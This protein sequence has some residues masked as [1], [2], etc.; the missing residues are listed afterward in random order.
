MTMHLLDCR[1]TSV[2]LA[3]SRDLDE[4]PFWERLTYQS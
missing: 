4:L 3:G 2:V 1:A